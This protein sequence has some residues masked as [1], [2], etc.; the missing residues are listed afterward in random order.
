MRA[1]EVELGE[2]GPVR[3]GHPAMGVPQLDP[4]ARQRRPARHRDERRVLARRHRR[5]LEG[6]VHQ[7]VVTGRGDRRGINRGQG[8]RHD[9]RRRGVHGVHLALGHQAVEP[10]VSHA[11][12]SGRV[13]VDAVGRQAGGRDP[14]VHQGHAKRAVAVGHHAFEPLVEGPDGVVVGPVR[15]AVGRPDVAA[16]RR[17]LHQL[18]HRAGPRAHDLVE[19]DLHLGQ[20]RAGTVAKPDVVGAQVQQD[21]V[22]GGHPRV[23]DEEP[24]GCLVAGVDRVAVAS[25][26]VADR[27]VDRFG[28]P[29]DRLAGITVVV[30]VGDAA[31][32]VHP[33]EI[34]AQVA[35]SQHVLKRP[36]VSPGRGRVLVHAVGVGIPEGHD[37]GHSALHELVGCRTP[38]RNSPKAQTLLFVPQDRSC[39]G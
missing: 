27:L 25:V 38:Q 34:E 1:R 39:A 20:H 9:H 37:P 31:V 2:V 16:D 19:K 23:L 32:A 33:H 13:H 10:G 36:A 12:V 30:G 18:D 7:E 24:G 4:P 21:D 29:V 17:Q 35:A 6:P 14:A 22:V 11:A 26:A 15:I 5:G 8:R 28:E 3:G